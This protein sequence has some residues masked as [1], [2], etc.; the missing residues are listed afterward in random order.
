MIETPALPSPLL[1]R[2]TLFNHDFIILK[3]AKPPPLFKQEARCH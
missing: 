2:E 3:T 1:R